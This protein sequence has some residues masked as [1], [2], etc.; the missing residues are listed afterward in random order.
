MEEAGASDDETRCEERGE[1]E[2]GGKKLTRL[3]AVAAAVCSVCLSVP[4]S[5]QHR[6]G[7]DVARQNG[8]RV[9][10]EKKKNTDRNTGCREK[11][12]KKRF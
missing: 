12:K 3:T 4:V 11:Q 7:E 1:K 8:K 6:G 9:I 5:L 10:C 2:R